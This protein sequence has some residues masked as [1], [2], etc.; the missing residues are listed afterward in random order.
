MKLVAPFLSGFLLLGCAGPSPYNYSEYKQA[1]PRSILVLP[2]VNKTTD[3]K[4]TLG[5]YSNTQKPLAEAGYYV[6]PV[7]VVYETFKNNGYTVSDDIHQIGASKLHEI[8]GADAAMYI[9]VKDYGTRY[10]VFGSV[11]VVTAEAILVD[12]RSGKKIWEGTATASSEEGKNNQGGLAALLI[13]AIAKQI[14]GTAVDESYGV[15]K[16]TNLRLLS[17][18]LKN[19]VLY[20]PY[21][22]DYGKPTN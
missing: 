18:G 21:H 10:F 15:S 9:T 11:S 16:I 3:T 19:G 13:S 14:V 20:G 4:A 1:N 2:P 22:P 17:A 5:F 7:A 12:L 8:F 6:F